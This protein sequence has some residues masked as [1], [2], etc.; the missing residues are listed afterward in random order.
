[1]ARMVA[2]G[3]RRSWDTQATSSRRERLEIPLALAGGAQPARTSSSSSAASAANSTGTAVDAGRVAAAVEATDVVVRGQP[4]GEGADPAGTGAD[5]L[6][7]LQRRA[8]GHRGACGQHAEQR[9]EVVGGDEHGRAAD[10]R[11]GHRGQQERRARHDQRLAAQR[12]AP[13]AVK[14]DPARDGRDRTPRPRTARPARPCRATMR[15]PR[16][17]TR[18]PA[19]GPHR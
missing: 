17:P 8:D 10:H 4:T 9:L 16:P 13:E 7:E 18:P 19:P 1:M 15:R 3:L 5:L 11:A 6:A 12:A 2:I 14:H